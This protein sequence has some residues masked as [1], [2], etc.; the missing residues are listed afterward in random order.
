[1]RAGSDVER[2]GEGG[3]EATLPS[4][5]GASV[6][7]RRSSRNRACRRRFDARPSAVL[8]HARLRRRL[9]SRRRSAEHP[10]QQAPAAAHDRQNACTPPHPTHRPNRPSN[11]KPLLTE[12][13]DARGDWRHAVHRR[14]RC[15]VPAAR[16][17]VYQHPGPHLSDLRVLHRHRHPTRRRRDPL[18]ICR[19][20]QIT[21]QGCR[22]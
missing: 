7:R 3:V 10:R 6:T 9:P 18:T 17:R 2:D 1:M 4:G 13:L 11:A 22:R 20:R 5:N 19:P 12:R 15:R 16:A 14:A 21:A 8:D